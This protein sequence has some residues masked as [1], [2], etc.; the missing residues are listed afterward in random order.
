[1]NVIPLQNGNFVSWFILLQ[2]IGLCWKLPLNL[3]HNAEWSFSGN[4]M[5]DPLV[6]ST[7]PYG[8][9]TSFSVHSHLVQYKPPNFSF[10]T[11]LRRLWVMSYASIHSKTPKKKRSIDQSINLKLFSLKGDLNYDIWQSGISVKRHFHL[12]LNYRNGSDNLIEVS[13]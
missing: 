12:I 5:L 4:T 10:H 7:N 1:M 11:L 3:T 13:L 6:Q 9:P 2:C 8:S